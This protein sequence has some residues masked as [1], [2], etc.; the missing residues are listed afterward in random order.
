MLSH[1]LYF[2]FQVYILSGKRKFK[3]I[4]FEGSC[5]M[6][7]LPH[8]FYFTLLANHLMLVII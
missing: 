4:V 3:K 2:A 7:F 5:R 6:N 8:V 1:H